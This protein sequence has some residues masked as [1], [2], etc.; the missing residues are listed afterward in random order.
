MHGATAIPAAFTVTQDARTVVVRFD[1]AISIGPQGK[2][3]LKAIH[4]RTGELNPT[5]QGNYPIGIEFVNAGS[6]SGATQAIA[7][8]TERPVPNIAAYNQ[9]HAGRDEEWQRVKPGE[10]AA[11]P[12]DFLVT[13]A[14][15]ARSSMSLRAETDGTLAIL[16]DGQRIGSI[17]A[18]GVPITITPENFGPGFSRLGIIRVHAR[19]GSQPGTAEIIAALDGGT[20]YNIKL[21]VQ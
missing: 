8:I 19:A 17:R 5:T 14:D 11:I 16:S 20:Q 13:L 2:P 15:V 6:L 10:E 9:L 7:S 4:V 12:I 18:R 3:G 21:V 1:Q